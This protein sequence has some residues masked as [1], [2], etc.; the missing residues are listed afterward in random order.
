MQPISFQVY[1]KE[2]KTRFAQGKSFYFYKGQ[3]R[4]LIK[5][6]KKKKQVECLLQFVVKFFFLFRK[7]LDWMMEAKIKVFLIFRFIY[8]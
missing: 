7:T 8:I 6:A 4:K 3:K 2:A 1:K 5:I